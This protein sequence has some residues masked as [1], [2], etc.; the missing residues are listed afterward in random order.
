MAPANSG[1]FEGIYGGE[2]PTAREKAVKAFNP[3][4][5]FDIDLGLTKKRSTKN[6]MTKV[7]GAGVLL[8]SPRST[9]RYG[10]RA[11]SHLPKW[12][13]ILTFIGTAAILFSV[14]ST[15]LSREPYHGAQSPASPAATIPLCR[16]AFPAEYLGTGNIRAIEAITVR[17]LGVRRKLPGSLGRG[18][19]EGEGVDF[20]WCGCGVVGLRLV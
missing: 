18:R 6:M 10:A 4:D 8:S 7:P 13:K 17:R 12:M 14:I 5:E 19:M 11:G 1:L 15:I 20:R 2:F 3:Y 16:D 9:R